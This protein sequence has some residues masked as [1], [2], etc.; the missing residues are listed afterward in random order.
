MTKSRGKV[1][2]RRSRLERVRER[3]QS[4]PSIGTANFRNSVQF[5]KFV[6]RVSRKATGTSPTNPGKYTQP[7]SP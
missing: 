4:T 2:N 3:G 7:V 5:V 6:F 1:D